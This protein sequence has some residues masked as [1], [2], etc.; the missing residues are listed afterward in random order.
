VTVSI[1]LELV[2]VG[3]VSF[4]FFFFRV[5]LVLLLL[6]RVQLFRWRDRP[7][8]ATWLLRHVYSEHDRSSRTKLFR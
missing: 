2:V 3:N 6:A 8:S 7:I 5:A 1:D 4:L